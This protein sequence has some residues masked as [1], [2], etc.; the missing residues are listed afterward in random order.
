M[1]GMIEIGGRAAGID[2]DG[3]RRRVDPNAAHLREIN[4]QAIVAAAE[5]GTVVAST[6]DR[7]KELVLAREVDRGNDVGGAGTSRD[8]PGPLVDH[9]VVQRT[10]I[11]VVLAGR[12]D[13]PPGEA[14]THQLG[15]GPPPRGIAVPSRVGGSAPP[16]LGS[17][18]GSSITFS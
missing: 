5:P 15:Q 3:A 9:A 10:G 6:A 7:E 4:D 18:V 8:H 11:V 16:R 12:P 1:R 14:L 2:P 13:A 17:R